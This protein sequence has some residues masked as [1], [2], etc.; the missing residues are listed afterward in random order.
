[1][2]T[3]P[4]RRLSCGFLA[5]T[6][7]LTACTAPRQAHVLN[8]DVPPLMAH[9]TTV[10][11]ID[12]EH[13]ALEL[14]I[15]PVARA[16]DGALKLRFVATEGSLPSVT[17]D[18]AGLK[19]YSVL[20]SGGHDLAYFQKG[21][22]LTIVLARTLQRGSSEE[23]E[24]RYGGTPKKGLWFSGLERG[25][26]TQIFTQGECEDA[27]WWFPCIDDPSDRATSELTVTLPAGWTAVAAGERVDRSETSGSVTEHWRMNFPHPVYL[28]TL[29]A[30]DFAVVNADWDG[31][32]LMYIGEPKYAD[33]LA[34]SFAPTPSV[35]AFMSEKTGLRYPYPKY[36]Q[37]C[38]DDFPFGGMEN[39]SATTMTETMLRG[40]RGLRDS[41]ATGL[42]AHEAAHQWFGN[43]LTANSW[44]HIWLNEGF[45]T[46][47]TQLYFESTKGDDELRMRWYDSLQGYLAKDVGPQRRPTV[48][49]T[50]RDPIDL[51][52]SG[53]TYAGGAARLH[54]LRFVLGDAN[55][56]AGIRT[57]VA[58]NQGRGVTTYDLKAAM[59]KASGRNLTAFFDQWLFGEGYPEL[60]VSWSYSEKDRAVRLTV[61]QTQRELAGTPGV[62]QLPVDIAV[63]T[64][65]GTVVH[66][67]EVDKR[68]SVFQLPSDIV[69]EY[70]WFDKGGWVPAKVTR[71][72]APA[73]W[74]TL[75]ASSDHA[76]MRRLAIEALGESFAGG[77]AF[78]LRTDQKDFARAELVNRLR[79]DTSSWV[80]VAAAK[81]LGQD[82][83]PEARL[84]LMAAAASDPNTFVRQA[85]FGALEG[86][87]EDLEL[88]AFARKQYQ[89]A[90]SW[91]SMGSAAKLLAT[92]DPKG[93]FQWTLRELFV[94][95]SP[96]DVLRAD[97]LGVMANLDHFRANAQLIQ[98]ATDRTADYGARIAA[99]RGLGQ[100]TTL[101]KKART[102]L[103]GLLGE[104]NAGLRRA[105]VESLAS[106]DDAVSKTALRDYYALS[107]SPREKRT[108]E[109][110]FGR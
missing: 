110:A 24:I 5:S 81:A 99:V 92:S 33:Y 48:Y 19:V 23:L 55:F 7:L 6:L 22:K 13:Y 59:E 41:D 105:V 64:A 109:A 62:F 82:A 50:Y 49:N 70:V 100:G 60:N 76:L 32:P 104:R 51:F 103:I 58:E 108:I 45:A 35:L 91:R 67:V 39:V 44:D 96:H 27:H 2:R 47:M 42:I 107:V 73:E 80:R 78:D 46:Y 88:A 97:L 63:R 18:L 43:L 28:T 25:V 69:P 101:D 40:E 77:V 37:A 38:V 75:A 21:E 57:Y 1:M 36:S 4:L 10:A 95:D 89:V 98:W 14:T 93:I 3:T 106:Y 11:A 85:A 102:T 15:D 71:E 84:R 79:Q 72:K 16:I 29:V 34:Q 20:D 68:T 12:A 30:G 83:S 9:P 52:F 94:A 61:A 66:R 26:A 86:W 87:G 54:Y 8:M 53:H 31:I 65:K 17:L 74:L 90:Y 56:F